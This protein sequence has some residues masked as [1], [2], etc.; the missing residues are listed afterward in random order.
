MLTYTN[1][2]EKLN[3]PEY[4]RNIQ[5]M[6]EHCLTIEDRKE[7]TACANAIVQ[8]LT[9]LFPS[10]TPDREE[11]LRKLWDQLYI[12]SDF[13]L[14]VDVPFE[15]I[16]AENLE[17]SPE[18]LPLPNHPQMTFRH[19]G[20]IIEQLIEKAA[21]MENSDEKVELVY[22]I[23]NQMKRTRAAFEGE[24][25]DERIFNDLHYLSKGA[26]NV[27][28]GA[29][30]LSVSDSSTAQTTSGSKKKKKR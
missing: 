29:M 5:K 20:F 14:D 17:G 15:P 27:P 1:H 6:V 7:R 4:G 9:K 26:I 18:H 11:Y 30:V 8:T 23:A 13:K 16:K 2:L 3:L 12:I 10:N 25:D 24:T 28:K 22:L 21:K 19:Y